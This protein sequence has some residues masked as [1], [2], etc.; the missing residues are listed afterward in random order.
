MTNLKHENKYLFLLFLTVGILI[1]GV[2]HTDKILFIIHSLS[3]Y[4][5]CHI[6]AMK[7]FYYE[8]EVI[9]N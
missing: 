8:N 7:Y 4:T 3:C 1:L 9:K 2:L 5:G 6:F